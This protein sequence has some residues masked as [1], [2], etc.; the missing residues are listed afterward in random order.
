MAFKASSAFEEDVA[1]EAEAP[2]ADFSSMFGEEGAED[3]LMEAL[4]GAGY[5]VTPEQISSI[6]GILE[7]GAGKPFGGTE[8]PEEEASEA[9]SRPASQNPFA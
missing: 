1:P 4:Q 9:G 5:Q 8:T 7:G 6:K 3:P 2:E